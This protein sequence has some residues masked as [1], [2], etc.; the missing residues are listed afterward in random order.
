MTNEELSSMSV[1]QINKYL[2]EVDESNKFPINGRFNVT[3]RAIRKVQ[4]LKKEMEIHDG[5]EYYL[6]VTSE[7]R[8]MVNDERNW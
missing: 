3:E 7:I 6:A 4:K 8:L 1:R 5:L 2:R